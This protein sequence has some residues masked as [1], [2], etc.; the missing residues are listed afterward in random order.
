MADAGVLYMVQYMSEPKRAHESADSVTFLHRL[1]HE[2]TQSTFGLAA[3]L[4]VWRRSAGSPVGI[5]AGYGAVRRGD[6][7]Q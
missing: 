7:D 3:A 5:L 6:R 2:V 4:T 1:P